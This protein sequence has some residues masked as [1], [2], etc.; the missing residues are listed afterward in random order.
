MRRKLG[1]LALTGLL[2]TGFGFLATNA[3]AMTFHRQPGIARIHNEG[4]GYQRFDMGRHYTR[5]HEGRRFEGRGRF[6]RL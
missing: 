3:Q 5:F 2:A 6:G 4:R 1:M